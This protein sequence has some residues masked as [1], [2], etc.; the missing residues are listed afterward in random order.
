MHLNQQMDVSRDD[1]QF[2]HDTSFLAAHSRKE[3][4]KES[5]DRRIDQGSPVPSDPGDVQVDSIAH[6][7]VWRDADADA[8]SDMRV[9]THFCA[10]SSSDS[11]EPRLY[12]AMTRCKPAALR[13]MLVHSDMRVLDHFARSVHLTVPSRGFTPR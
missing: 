5:G 7:T 3:S 8:L 6:D 4:G 1:V 11:S 13:A 9:L 2:K 10:V 12:A